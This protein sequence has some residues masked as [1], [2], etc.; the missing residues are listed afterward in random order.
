L[1]RFDEQKLITGKV[2]QLCDQ[3]R[4]IVVQCKTVVLVSTSLPK[5]LRL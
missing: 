1:L 4:R 3:S 2:D 5:R